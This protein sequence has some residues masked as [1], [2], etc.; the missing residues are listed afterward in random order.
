VLTENRQFDEAE[1]ACKS[2]LEYSSPQMRGAVY[3]QLARTYLA[4]GQY[5]SALDAVEGALG[6]NPNAPDALLVLVKVYRERGDRRMVSEVGQRLRDLWNNADP[7]FL[8]L[9]ELRR[10]LAT[11]RKN[12]G[13]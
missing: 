12:P 11:P 8:P 5:E 7:D 2:A 13:T 4:S 10:L 6:V 9:I 1:Q 3:S